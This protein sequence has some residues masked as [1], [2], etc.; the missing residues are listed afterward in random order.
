MARSNQAT[1]KLKFF[2]ISAVFLFQ[3]TAMADLYDH[4][5]VGTVS[6][7]GDDA[8]ELYRALN[9]PVTFTNG[10]FRAPSK[11]KRDNWGELRILCDTFLAVTCQFSW[12]LGSFDRVI[13]IKSENPEQALCNSEIRVD[14]DT[15]QFRCSGN[16]LRIEQVVVKKNED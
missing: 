16:E 6:V 12:D 10:G 8:V 14:S 11:I 7:T 9:I 2:L 15:L 13:Q 5:D 1:N 3:T 4:W